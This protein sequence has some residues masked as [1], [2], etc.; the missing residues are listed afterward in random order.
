IPAE[1]CSLRCCL[2]LRGATQPV[3]P[4][5]RSEGGIRRPARLCSRW[6]CDPARWVTPWLDGPGR[7]GSAR[8]RRA[9]PPLAGAPRTAGNDGKPIDLLVNNAGGQLGLGNFLDRDRDHLTAEGFLNALALER[10]THAAL[11][12]MVSRG[13]GNVI[14]VS[15]GVAFYPTPG[16]VG[17]GASKAFVNSFT[18]GLDYEL[19]G[20]GVR[21]TAMCP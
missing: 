19:R 8:G 10:L 18:E 17:Y 3:S 16:A 15:A 13:L 6:W 7:S 5:E 12:P 11:G 20:T 4:I 9:P 1:S 21:V 2:R 14:N